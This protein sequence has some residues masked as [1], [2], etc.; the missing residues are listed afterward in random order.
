MTESAKASGSPRIRSAIRPSESL[1]PIDARTAVLAFIGAWFA[2]QMLSVIVLSI[3]GETGDSETPI[4]VLAVVLCTAWFA[5]VSTMW[6]VSERAGTADPVDDFG[7]RVLP[8]DLIGLGIGV[9]AQLVVIRVVYLPLEAVWPATFGD[10]ELQRNAEGLVDRASGVTTVVLFVLVV[11]G[12]P[13]VEELFYRGLLQR[14]LLARFNDVLVVVGVA[15]LFAVIHFRPV[16][17]P[18]LFV[19]GLIVGATA[20]IT[21]RLGMSIMTHIGFNLTGLLLVL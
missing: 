16:E 18:G 1:S 21:G 3:F 7:I 14:S 20:M 8:I 15:A 17:Y 9:L 2:A 12:A 19:F 5:Y 13:I 10:D 6:F 4:G 11:L